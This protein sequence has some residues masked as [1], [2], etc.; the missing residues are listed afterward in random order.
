MHFLQKRDIRTDE[1]TDRRTDRQ[2][3]TPSYRDAR[4]HLKMHE[5]EPNH[6]VNPSQMVTVYNRIQICFSIR[7]FD[8]G[9]T[10]GWQRKR[11]KAV[12]SSTPNMTKPLRA[13]T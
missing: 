7:P 12:I 5:N 2:T 6:P 11:D 1:R 9:L 13:P 10:K 8:V 3:D 4:T